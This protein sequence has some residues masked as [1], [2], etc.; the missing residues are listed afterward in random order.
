MLMIILWLLS[1][2]FLPYNYF[3]IIIIIIIIIILT[4]GIYTVKSRLPVLL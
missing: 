1:S 4:I 2:L 3:R